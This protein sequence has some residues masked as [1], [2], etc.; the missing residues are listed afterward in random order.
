[1]EYEEKQH[2]NL[3]WLYILLGIETIIIVS[4]LAFSKDGMSFQDLKDA[5]F[6]PVFAILFPYI[7]IYFVTK[8]SL[9]LKISECGINYHYWPFSKNKFV[10]WTQIESLY[11]RKYDA[12]G[13]YGG[14]GVKYRLWFKVK[15]KAYIFNDNTVGLQLILTNGKKLLFS[16]TKIDELTLFLI[17][18]K[19]KYNI[20]AIA[21]DVRER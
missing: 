12:L 18:L 9:T 2:L 14:W 3:W 17:N 8:N 19:R 1:M 7:I 11:L 13:E 20:G 10:S 15:D 6:L 5:Y 21:T 16:T 4:I